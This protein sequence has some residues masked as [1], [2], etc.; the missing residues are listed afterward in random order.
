[1]SNG[2]AGEYG[3]V[4]G[5]DFSTESAVQYGTYAPMMAPATAGTMLVS[6]TVAIPA[7]LASTGLSARGP[8]PVAPRAGV[9]SAMRRQRSRSFD[10]G[11]VNYASLPR[12]AGAPS[13]APPPPP[14]PPGVEAAT[15]ATST[16]APAMPM[17][18]AAPAM[19]PPRSTMMAGNA[20]M[21]LDR[22]G[23][24]A[25]A[26]SAFVDSGSATLSR[27]RKTLARTNRVNA[28]QRA[29]TM[30]FTASDAN[31]FSTF[32]TF[33]APLAFSQSERQPPR[34]PAPI[35]PD[36]PKLGGGGTTNIP[37]PIAIVPTRQLP[38]GP[39]PGAP[40][41]ESRISRMPDVP[42]LVVRESQ[43]LLTDDSG[44]EVS[45]LGLLSSRDALPLISA[46][47]GAAL[48][49]EQTLLNSVCRFLDPHKA[50]R[51]LLIEAIDAEM[52]ANPGSNVFR[53]TTSP[54]SVLLCTYATLVAQPYIVDTA[55]TTLEELARDP[56]VSDYNNLDHIQ[57]W[58]TGLLETAAA[59]LFDCPAPLAWLLATVR[60]CA[61]Q[62]NRSTAVTVAVAR[63]YFLRVICPALMT[64]VA[65]G[66]LAREP[67]QGVARAVRQ[68]C[69]VMKALA[70]LTT[71]KNDVPMI[72]LNSYLQSNYARMTS[73]VDS[74]SS[75]APSLASVPPLASLADADAIHMKYIRNLL[76]RKLPEI[77]KA[78]S[79][80]V[81]IRKINL[82]VNS[83]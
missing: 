73:I 50:L 3:S 51:A 38:P 30:A 78:L 53:D 8:P 14:P 12:H 4:E 13:A 6:P 10:N 59:S 35:A 9:S 16:Y 26:A 79:D 62:R 41:L 72:P 5:I 45:L 61:Q 82:I 67:S 34:I 22:R 57:R 2:P 37:A 23:T 11:V 64:P 47:Y 42:M 24:T 68:V 58:S 75:E 49:E 56:T 83:S 20:T 19:P 39:P 33:A 52:V 32:S 66:A 1:V 43:G 36:A 44:A 28:K 70:N 15:Y 7:P 21:T 81:L 54:A 77:E 25:A 80:I 31:T 69:K 76:Q 55:R 29:G 46:M 17:M 71:F 74:I 18:R 65:C 63:F 60:T 40:P 48:F 27:G